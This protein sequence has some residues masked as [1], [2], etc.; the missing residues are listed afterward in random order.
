MMQSYHEK[1]FNRLD[2]EEDND[3]K[4]HLGSLELKDSK[5]EEERHKKM[6]R[7]QSALQ[8]KSKYVNA[9]HDQAQIIDL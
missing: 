3:I 9:T 2:R 1:M 6:V 8:I 5:A 4:M 7:T